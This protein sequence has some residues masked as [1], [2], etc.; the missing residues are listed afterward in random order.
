MKRSTFNFQI[1]TP[2]SILIS[3]ILFC[4]P[5]QAQ[6]PAAIGKVNRI[7]SN[8][9][10]EER[11]IYV[12]LPEGAKVA[13]SLDRYPVVY[14]LDG[15]AHFYYTASM[16]H[17]LSFI[18][19]N[20]ICPEMIVVSISNTDRTRDLT[21]THIKDELPYLDSNFAKNSGGGEKFISFWEKELIPFI[22]SAYPTQP[23]R[24]LIGHSLGGLMAMHTFVHHTSLF[25]AYVA[26]DPS[27][28]WDRRK[29]L[30]EIK[31]NIKTSSYPGISLFMAIANTMEPGRDTVEI[32]KDTARSS[33]HIRSILELN[34]I[35][36]QNSS[37]QLKYKANYY[38]QE[39]HGSV[40]LIAT[41]DALHFIFDFYPLKISRKDNEDSTLSVIAVIEDHYKNVKFRL[42]YEVR[43][44]QD[45]INF[46]AVNAINR[47][48][49]RKAEALYNLNVNY[50]PASTRV[51]ETLGDFYLKLGEK[52]KAADQY[53][54]SLN[55]R[56]RP[57]IRQ[58]LNN[59]KLN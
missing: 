51:Y 29:L 1:F 7:F 33:R 17:Q 13:G 20:S 50:Y 53:K 54:K 38:D 15:S 28:W 39:S 37:N 25:N 27:M 44:P 59:L 18:N 30:N 8:I 47:N 49:F 26:I 4:L 14:V 9:L 12:Y 56:E 57:E 32:S 19:G 6:E 21:P 3:V 36:Q 5:L 42:G 10:N 31:T 40:P 11:S 46:Y 24:I 52:T 41:Y 35:M 43:P 48:H 23:F 22:D 2:V 45:L 58:K 55:L 16:I 34:T